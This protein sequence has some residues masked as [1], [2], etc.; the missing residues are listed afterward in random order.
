MSEIQRGHIS[1][2]PSLRRYILLLSESLFSQPS[3]S[4]LEATF[5]CNFHIELYHAATNAEGAQ[6]ISELFRE[7]VN[8]WAK[9]R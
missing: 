4:C 6:N 1:F 7:E 8:E 9:N 3:D 2:F 5:S